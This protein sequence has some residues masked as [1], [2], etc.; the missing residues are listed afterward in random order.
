MDGVTL[1]PGEGLVVGIGRAGF[2]AEIGTDGN[3]VRGNGF[4]VR[5][6]HRLF[7]FL[8]AGNGKDSRERKDAIEQFLHD[9]HSFQ[10]RH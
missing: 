7:N 10:V 8:V 6:G 1:N 3:R 4:E 9:L 2:G 5:D